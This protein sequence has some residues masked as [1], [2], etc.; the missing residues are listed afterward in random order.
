MCKKGIEE[1]GVCVSMRCKITTKKIKKGKKIFG[2]GGYCDCGNSI[3]CFLNRECVLRVVYM[4]V[5]RSLC[6]CVL[7]K[8]G[9]K[10]VSRWFIICLSLRV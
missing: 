5:C 6:V 4:C 10:L 1:A 3:K 9:G 2:A 7:K 8:V